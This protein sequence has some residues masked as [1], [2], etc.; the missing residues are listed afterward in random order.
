MKNDKIKSIGVAVAGSIF[1][2]FASPQLITAKSSL[3]P[4]IGVI[5]PVAAALISKR[6]YDDYKRWLKNRGEE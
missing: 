3:L 6:L 5:V 2:L 4:A 1:A